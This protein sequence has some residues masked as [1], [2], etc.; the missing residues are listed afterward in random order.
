MCGQVSPSTDTLVV[1]GSLWT[2][3]S[4][5]AKTVAPLLLLFL[6]C[7]QWWLMSPSTPSDSNSTD[8][9]PSMSRGTRTLLES[10]EGRAGE[11]GSKEKGIQ[12]FERE[13]NGR[14]GVADREGGEG[15]VEADVLGPDGVM[16]G[17][18]DTEKDK[19]EGVSGVDP[20]ASLQA[21]EKGAGQQGVSG[22]GA[23]VHKM[24][25]WDVLEEPMLQQQQQQAKHEDQQGSGNQD[26]KQQHPSDRQAGAW[27]LEGE[28]PLQR[29]PTPIHKAMAED[30]IPRFPRW[31]P[32]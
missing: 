11:G 19:Q 21:I 15:F 22:G 13:E 30:S 23:E 7:S 18:T 27:S 32:R 2:W 29:A 6:Y 28:Q 20:V 16:L 31:G 4:G 25:D 1:D 10:R 5:G 14:K 9:Q 3:E 24:R 8:R 12:N 17:H 26:P